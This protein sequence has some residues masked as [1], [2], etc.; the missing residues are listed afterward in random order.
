M[1]SLGGLLLLKF[2]LAYRSKPEMGR[3]GGRQRLSVTPDVITINSWWHMTHTNDVRQ[4]GH[5]QL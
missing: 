2:G 1:L 5:V 3:A 4:Q